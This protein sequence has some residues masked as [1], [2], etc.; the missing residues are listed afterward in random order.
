[1][2]N[3]GQNEMDNQFGWGMTKIIITNFGDTQFRRL[4]EKWEGCTKKDHKETDFEGVK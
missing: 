4:R 1:M 3:E 2:T